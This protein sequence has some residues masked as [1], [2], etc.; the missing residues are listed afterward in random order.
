VDPVRCDSLALQAR[1]DLGQE[2]DGTAQVEVVVE[3]CAAGL[4]FGRFLSY[5]VEQ[6]VAE[7][8]LRIV[9]KHYEPAPIPIHIV[10]AHARLMSSRVR[11]F[12]DWMKAEL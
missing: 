2:G 11:A 9:L 10:F 8:R 12:V 7:K 6:L 3:A 5:Q 1:L 4:G